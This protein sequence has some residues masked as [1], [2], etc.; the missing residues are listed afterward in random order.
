MASPLINNVLNQQSINQPIS[1]LSDEEESDSLFVQLT[2]S[3]SL[4]EMLALMQGNLAAITGLHSKLRAV[5]L[6]KME[7]GVD[8]QNNR[9][10]LAEGEG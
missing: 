6:K 5:L 8:S 4:S 10:A 3:L 7:G 9:K 2:S 1:S